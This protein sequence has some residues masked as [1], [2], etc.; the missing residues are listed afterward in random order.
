MPHTIAYNDLIQEPST[1][2]IV[3]MRFFLTFCVFPRFYS[4][5]H[6]LLTPQVSTLTSLIKEFRTGGNFGRSCESKISHYGRVKCIMLA[7]LNNPTAYDILSTDEP[8][9]SLIA[10]PN[11][12]H[13]IPILGGMPYPGGRL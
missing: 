8:F 7:N 11:E 1:P 6:R 9:Y 10:Y 13:S 3:H 4:Q 5:P 2:F 12:V